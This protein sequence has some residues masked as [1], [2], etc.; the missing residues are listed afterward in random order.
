MARASAFPDATLVPC[1]P[2]HVP[3][4]QRTTTKH[5]ACNEHHGSNATYKRVDAWQ[6]PTFAEIAPASGAISAWQRKEMARPVLDY[7]GMPPLQPTYGTGF[8][9]RV[10]WFLC[11][12]VD[13]QGDEEVPPEV[14]VLDTSEY[15]TV[16]DLL[17]QVFAAARSVACD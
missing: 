9:R 16:E 5:T 12:P 17:R 10:L 1:L 2:R 14:F 3:Q 7:S 8:V 11:I 6:G 13:L 4:T 15:P